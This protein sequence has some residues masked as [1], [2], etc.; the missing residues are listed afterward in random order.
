MTLRDRTMAMTLEEILASPRTAT[1]VVMGILNVTPDSFSDGGRFLDPSAAITH[2]ERMVAQGANILDVGAESTRPGSDAVSAE[3][4][5]DR[6]RDVLPALVSMG[7]VVSI[8]T[9]SSSVARFA[10]DTGAMLVNDVAAGRMDADILPLA[11]E[12]G[13]A[14]CLMHML[15][16]PK[17]MQADPQYDDVV[18]EVSAFLVHRMAAAVAAGVSKDHIIWDPGIGFGKRLEHNL[19]LLANLDVLANWGQPILIGASRKRFIGELTG[20][21]QA[22]DRLAG[23]LAA[24]IVS[25]PAATIFRVHDVA[26]TVGAIA[27][28]QAICDAR[29][30]R[31]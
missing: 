4:Q 17:T 16:E 5:I 14:V 8:D 20:Q 28:A 29:R 22:D 26:E 9:T 2:A 18:A 21:A 19:A 31:E 1:P 27:V 13:A 10:L 30:A 3:E 23:S 15:G 24:A 11:A 25:Y 12:R 6:L 7:V